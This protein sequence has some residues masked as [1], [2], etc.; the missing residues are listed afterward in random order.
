MK[1]AL[2][3]FALLVVAFMTIR[4]YTDFNPQPKQP[5]PTAFFAGNVLITCDLDEHAIPGGSNC[6]IP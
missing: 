4:K 3:L 1:A 5:A 6:R 2:A